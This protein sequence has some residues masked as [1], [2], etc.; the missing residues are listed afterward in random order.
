MFHRPRARHPI[1]NGSHSGV[2]TNT[3]ALVLCQEPPSASRGHCPYSFFGYRLGACSYTSPWLR[4]RTSKP[5]ANL[6][7]I[8]GGDG[9]AFIFY[10]GDR[11]RTPY[12]IFRCC[13]VCAQN[14]SPTNFQLS[15]DKMTFSSSRPIDHSGIPAAYYPHP[16]PQCRGMVPPPSIHNSQIRSMF[17]I[18]LT[19]VSFDWLQRPNHLHEVGRRVLHQSFQLPDDSSSL[20]QAPNNSNCSSWGSFLTKE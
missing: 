3:I 6:S 11:E 5:K 13:C 15:I 17:L 16:A 20:Y 10:R 9:P 18:P 19:I 2:S 8:K 14:G 4:P 12:Q 7:R 1:T